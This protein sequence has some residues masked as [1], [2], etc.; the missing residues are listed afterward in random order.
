G[1]IMTDLRR[2]SNEFRYTLEDEIRSIEVSERPAPRLEAVPAGVDGA[3][4]RDEHEPAEAA[5]VE[6][7]TSAAAD[8][9]LAGRA[10]HR[11]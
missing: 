3:I 10:A 4:T 6:A 5:E 1:K 7:A 2:A 8:E 9:E 11:P